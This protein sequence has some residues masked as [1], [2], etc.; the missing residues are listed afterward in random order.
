MWSRL[1]PAAG[2]RRVG[3][4][5]GSGFGWR[6]RHAR[7]EVRLTQ[8]HLADRADL[9][10]QWIAKIESGRSEPRLSDALA[11]FDVL[12]EESPGLRLEWLLAGRGPEHGT[13]DDGVER[14]RF[15]KLL[16]MLLVP[17]TLPVTLDLERLTSGARTE[18][19]L[20]DSWE[21][22]NAQY[23]N[24]RP[25]ERPDELL[26]MVEA[27]LHRLRTRLGAEVLS[28]GVRRRVLSVTAGAAALAGWISITAERR[29]D[30]RSHLTLAEA[31]A[32]EAGDQNALVLILMLQADLVSVVPTGGQGGLPELARRHLDETISLTGAA[33]PLALSAPALLRSAEEHA[34]V[35]RRPI[36]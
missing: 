18:A 31:L 25:M 6:L 33:T 29:R 14:R 32:R 22:L 19:S 4:A 12:A 21:L 15:S 36:R 24:L 10:R 5:G 26:P 1:G 7:D 23:A 2:R 30:A 13:V 9:S 27:H 28:D 16:G 35:G 8:E 17:A 3:N 34:Y 20:I 11:L